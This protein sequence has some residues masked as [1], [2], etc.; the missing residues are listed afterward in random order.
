MVS[1]AYE[2]EP[3]EEYDEQEL[4]LSILHHDSRNGNILRMLLCEDGQG[5]R[6]AKHFG[7]R[8]VKRIAY[9]SS[10]NDAYVSIN[11]FK[12]FRRKSESVYNFGAIY[13]DL[14]GHDFP[15]VKEMDAAIERTKNRLR[16]A[17]EG[18]EVTAPTMITHTGRGL[19]IFYV[20]TNSIANVAKARKSV[21]YLDQIRA[22]MTAKYKRLL[23]DDGYLDVDT[24]VK[25]YSRV[26][27]IPLTYNHA[28]ER[29]C[30]LI[31]VNYNEEGE[32]EYSDLRALARDN[33]LFDQ[34]N[35]VK[36][37]VASQKIVS[38]DA[39]RLPFL[40]IRLQKL[41]IL[42]KIRDYDCSGHREYMVFVHYNSAKQIYGEEQGLI[43]TKAFNKRFR[44]PLDDSEVEH[45]AMIVNKNIAPSQDYQGFY[46]LPDAWVMDVLDVTEEENRACRF[47]ASKREIERQQIKEHNAK[48]RQDRDEAVANQV[49]NHPE[50]SYEDIGKMFGI[51]SKTVQRIAAKCGVSRYKKAEKESNIALVSGNGTNGQKMADSLSVSFGKGEGL[52]PVNTVQDVVVAE[53]AL[54][55]AYADLYGAVTDTRKRGR[56]ISGQL[57]FRWGRDGDIG[58]YMIS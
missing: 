2:L 36:K 26:C 54:V 37:S 50:Q 39:Y 7:N 11:T 3:L 22:A 43:V 57:A 56:P 21:R 24:T 30:R 20:L 48:K 34:I 12:G 47:G 18:G 19:G 40:T 51:S 23:S 10:I 45:A 16:R 9:R 52:A 15:T 25:D 42:Q 46:K 1:E 32:V 33:H 31:Y 35:D 14:D 4:F 27:R 38:L 29:W 49:E 8:D 44:V 13:I 28:A 58:Y 53:D 41:D 5:K 55:Q 17:Y 6:F